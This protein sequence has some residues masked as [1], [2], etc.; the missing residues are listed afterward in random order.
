MNADC[1]FPKCT[2]KLKLFDNKKTPKGAYK[3]SVC[4]SI[5]R[6]IVVE[7][8][9]DAKFSGT[10]KIPLKETKIKKKVK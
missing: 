4:G 1:P 3:C 7:N 2:G 5:F 9:Y 8:N 10:K 6:F